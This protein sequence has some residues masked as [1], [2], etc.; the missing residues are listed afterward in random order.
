MKPLPALPRIAVAICTYNRNDALTVLLEALLVSVARV[1]GRAHVGVVVVDDSAEG[2]AGGVVEKFVGRFELGITYRISGRKNISLARNLAIE[3]GSEMADWTAMIDDDCEPVPE[4]L[5]AMLETQQR[6]GADA[7]T[8]TMVRR[9]AE[10]SPRWIIEEPF[11]EV[12]LHR[13]DDCAELPLASTFN[14]IISSRWLKDHPTIRFRPD[15]GVT[16]GEDMVFYGAAHAVG[17]RIHYSSRAF[18]Y[19]NQPLSRATFS[20]WLRAFFWYGNTTYLTN[21]WNGTHS[22]RM[23]LRGGNALRKALVRPIARLCR[24]ERPQVRY[25]LASILYAIGMIIGVFGVK[26]E[27]PS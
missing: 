14:S 6:T 24:G 18:V 20:Y 3:T 19:E 21:V 27:H 25:C 9:V 1:A 16:G 7:V 5:E 17:L 15:Y 12:G 4:W 11:L 23:F 10:G 2:K 8:G 22:F 26:V 13:F